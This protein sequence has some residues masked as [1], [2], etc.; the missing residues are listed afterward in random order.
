[1]VELV[2]HSGA[3]DYVEFLADYAPYDLYAL[4]NLGRAIQLFDH[5]S[6]MIKIEQQPR[7]YMASKA[8]QSGFQNVLFTDVR[9]VADVEECVAAVRPETPELRGKQGATASREV[10]VLLEVGSAAF[11]QARKDSVVA[12]MIEKKDA[13]DN[14]DALLSVKGLDMVQFGPADYAIS[15]GLA[16]MRDHPSVR[17]AEE[18]MIATALKKGIVPRGEIR[19][20]EQAER[21]LKLG[22]KHFCLGWD[23][24][25]LF[26]WYK[27]NGARLHQM[28][29]DTHQNPL[30]PS[31]RRE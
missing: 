29:A 20:P 3:F 25:I 12:I 23:Y 4:E 24:R 27:E 1:M 8:L 16:G 9:T 11:V 19:E 5:M 7:I 6:G 21:Y 15:I 28:L 2:G 26:D 14:L 17:E 22:V 10:G 31:R 30:D 18:F 13:I